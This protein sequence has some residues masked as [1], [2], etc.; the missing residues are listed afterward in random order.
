[1]VNF[2]SSRDL[3]MVCSPTVQAFSYYLTNKCIVNCYFRGSD[4]QLN[5]FA[6]DCVWMPGY[7]L[8]L[9]SCGNFLHHH[10][11]L[12]FLLQSAFKK[13]SKFWCFR[14]PRVRGRRM[15]ICSSLAQWSVVVWAELATE[16]D[17]CSNPYGGGSYGA[18]VYLSNRTWRKEHRWQLPRP[19]LVRRS[20]S[21]WGSR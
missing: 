13:K 1:M 6:I 7:D 9:P 10:Q 18:S 8:P 12:T 21:S 4:H 16:N 14:R 15:Q 11:M 2:L 20:L 19:V 5:S 3:A 17:R